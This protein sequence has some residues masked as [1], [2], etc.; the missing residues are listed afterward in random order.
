ML[1]GMS[2]LGNQSQAAQSS[3]CGQC[4]QAA[5]ARLCGTLAKF[6]RRSTL[7]REAPMIETGDGLYLAGFTGLLCTSLSDRPREGNSNI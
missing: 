5:L 3:R 6:G 4:S 2:D 7:W 1:A